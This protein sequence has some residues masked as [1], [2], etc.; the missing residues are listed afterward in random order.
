[1]LIKYK[2]GDLA[3]DL[4]L[5]NKDV[6]A[7]MGSFGADKKHTTVL[8]E[9][10]LNFVFDALTQKHSAPNF[11]QYFVESKGGAS[12]TQ[13]AAQADKQAAAPQGG[14]P[15]QAKPQGQGQ[16]PGQQRPAEPRIRPE[17]TPKPDKPVEV[18]E[19]VS[20]VVDTRAAVVDI[21]K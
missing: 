16:R 13:P 2:L 3:K 4:G 14:K 15:Q 11:D 9:D 17:K 7:A 19:R 21:D 1:M 12:A 10:E 8:T 6:I 5:P 20:R 18:K